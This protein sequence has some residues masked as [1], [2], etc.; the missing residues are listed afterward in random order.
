[1]LWMKQLKKK[2]KMKNPLV[3]C[4][5]KDDVNFSHEWP[6]NTPPPQKKIVGE[7]ISVILNVKLPWDLKN[8][9]G[10]NYNSEDK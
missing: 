3:L 8:E 10:M 9:K 6:C 1:M 7:K 4:G 5:R 2:V